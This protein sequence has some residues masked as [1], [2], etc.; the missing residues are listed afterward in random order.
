MGKIIRAT[1]PA[2][3]SI[4]ILA[5]VFIIACLLSHQI[6]NVPF[7]DLDRNKNIYF[8]MLLVG[9]AVIIMLLIIWEEILFPIKVIEVNG[10]MIFRNHR[11]KLITQLL[12]YCSIP[13]IFGFIYFEYEVNQ[14]RFFIWAAV[15]MVAPVLE[16]IASGL[17]NYN[18]YLKLTDKK[19]EFKDNEREGTFETQELQ[20][21]TILKD[22]R[23]I[24]HKIQLL[25]KNNDQIIID[26]DKMELE[27]FYESINKFIET[28]YK[29]LLR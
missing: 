3:F 17:N 16:K 8:G 2:E 25:S 27:A 29:N 22:E 15:C 18:D 7:H 11:T 12:I 19:I 14:I 24:F 23:N 10:G 5:L 13:A 9:A 26:L 4:G 6:F 20:S 21:I 1:Y 28:H